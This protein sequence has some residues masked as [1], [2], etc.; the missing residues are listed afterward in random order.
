MCSGG[1][2]GLHFG[3]IAGMHVWGTNDLK[4]GLYSNLESSFLFDKD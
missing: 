3:L 4:G 2:S 1:S